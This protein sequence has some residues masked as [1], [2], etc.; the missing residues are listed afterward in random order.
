MLQ[1]R[2]PLAFGLFDHAF[3][4]LLW[5]QLHRVITCFLPQGSTLVSS[6]VQRISG[7][8]TAAMRFTQHV[9]PRQ[10]PSMVSGYKGS[11]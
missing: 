7:A 8:K 11:Q 10:R 4:D 3:G 2:R 5:S 6:A 9:R 1:Q